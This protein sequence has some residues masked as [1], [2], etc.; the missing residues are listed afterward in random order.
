MLTKSPY[1]SIGR[2]TNA[3]TNRS[4]LDRSNTSRADVNLIPRY[5]Q[6]RARCIQMETERAPHSKR[7][8]T[9]IC[10]SCPSPFECR[11][12]LSL[13]S[14]RCLNAISLCDTLGRAAANCA[15]KISHVHHEPF[16][17]RHRWISPLAKCF[18]VR[19]GA[20]PP[21]AKLCP[22]QMLVSGKHEPLKKTLFILELLLPLRDSSS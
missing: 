9:K 16:R 11:D 21:P 15:S 12:T 14:G 4:M 1:P 5:A 17:E 2:W 3:V 6:T 10:V 13:V 7:M 18:K 8:N 19:G 22:N 20:T